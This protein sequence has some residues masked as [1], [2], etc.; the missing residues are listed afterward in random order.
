MKLCADANVSVS[1]ASSSPSASSSSSSSFSSSS[2]PS[3]SSSSSSPSSSHSSSSSSSSLSSSEASSS[4]LPPPLQLLLLFV[5]Q[6][7]QCLNQFPLVIRT[8]CL[9]RIMAREIQTEVCL[10]GGRRIGMRIMTF[11]TETYC[12]IAITTDFEQRLALGLFFMSVESGHLYQHCFFV[13][14]QL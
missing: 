6:H 11:V 13:I 4:P 10:L 2:S 1:S 5:V 7:S 14:L 8:R 3:L 12:L 9:K